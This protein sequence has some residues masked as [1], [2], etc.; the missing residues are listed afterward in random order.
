[1]S[2]DSNVA[3]VTANS[4]RD[5]ARAGGRV[6]RARADQAAWAI[7][8]IRELPE[9]FKQLERD[10]QEAQRL[11]QRVAELTDVVAEVLVPAADRD[12]AR[13]RAALAKYHET[14]F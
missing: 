14:S 12:D 3:E 4:L 5:S 7:A 9:R 1:M 13:V 2:T 8:K 6:L 10:V 11:H